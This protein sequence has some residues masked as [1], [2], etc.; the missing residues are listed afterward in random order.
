VAVLPLE[1]LSGDPE[2]EYFA[3]G[4]TEAL[5]T[6]LAK[7]GALR[8]VS[9][10]TAMQY[11]RAS[12]PLPQIAVDLQVDGI[13]EGTVLRSGNR[14]RIWAQLMDAQADSHIWAESYERDVRDILALHSELARA[15]AGQ[16]QIALTPAEQSQLGPG[17]PVHPEAYEAYLKGRHHWNRRTSG[18]LK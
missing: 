1:N 12:K 16:I 2:Q 5:I 15:I 14:V 13:V 9:R 17:R 7:I 18:D 6:S 11:K 8:V 3:D 4:L 10:T